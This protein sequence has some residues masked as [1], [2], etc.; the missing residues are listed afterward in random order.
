MVLGTKTHGYK[1]LAC[2]QQVVSAPHPHGACLLPGP[3]AA[4]QTPVISPQLTLPEWEPTECALESRQKDTLCARGR[5][6]LANQGIQV[7]KGD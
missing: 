3:H 2:G 5:V 6:Q 4:G 1:K 7:Q